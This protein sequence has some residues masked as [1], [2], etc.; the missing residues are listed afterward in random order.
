MNLITPKI[1]EGEDPRQRELR[2]I[3]TTRGARLE[4]Y[5][6]LGRAGQ[7]SKWV[8]TV[9]S[10]LLIGISLASALDLVGGTVHAAAVIDF[11][12]ALG[13]VCILAVSAIEYGKSYELRSDR[14]HRAALELGRLYDGAL[15]DTLSDASGLITSYNAILDRFSEN[16]EPIDY[17]MFAVRHPGDFNV[18]WVQRQ[19]IRLLWHGA[20]QRAWLIIAAIC[21]GAVVLLKLSAGAT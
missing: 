3:W 5:R 7:A 4:A 2:K 13:A 1:V 12:S 14:H 9:A 11:L 20:A 17:H 19:T 6:R 18:G 8:V 16:H 10:I 21:I 15:A